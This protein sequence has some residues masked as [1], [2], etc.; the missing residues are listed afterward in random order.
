MSTPQKSLFSLLSFCQ[1]FSQSVEIWQSSDKKVFL[2]HG[3]VQHNKCGLRC[4]GSED[5]ASE[6][7]K[8]AIFDHPTSFDAYSYCSVTAAAA[9]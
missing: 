1:K 9:N 7:A 5:I 3:V 8:I 6:K 4:E 2:R